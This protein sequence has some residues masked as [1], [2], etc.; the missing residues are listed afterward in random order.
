MMRTLFRAALL[1]LLML[2]AV[3]APRAATAA[4]MAFGYLE[5]TG[6]DA[7][8]DYLE[9]I[10]P[11]SFASSIRD[12]FVV[13]VMKPD[14]IEAK[15]KKRG[16]TLKK[17]FKQREL[18]KYT[19]AMGAD[20]FIYGSFRILPGNAIAIKLNL[21]QKK[22]NKLFTFI[23]EGKMET[24]IFRLVD[25]VTRIMVQMLAKSNSYRNKPVAPRSKIAVLTNLDDE[26]LNRLYFMLFQK[27]YTVSAVQANGGLRPLDKKLLSIFKNVTSRD[28]SFDIATSPKGP[29]LLTGTW[30]GERHAK[31]IKEL[32]RF[33]NEYDDDYIA[34]KF[35]ILD[36][37][38]ARGVDY[39]MVICFERNG[40][41]IRCIDLKKKDIIWIQANIRGSTE[42]ICRT[43]TENMGTMPAVEKQ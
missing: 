13:D 36:R 31:R 26:Q 41:W 10:F 16:L 18:P 34:T 20:F 1:C 29:V 38:S 4:T 35:K 42:K 39:L 37:L 9:K 6:R 22:R 40:A 43:I 33:M 5:N 30:A 7:N 2:A 27:G 24:E 11:N 32:S 21:Y 12:I 25:R 15:L 14:Q 17:Q 23:N 19:K 28:N 8:Y 3:V